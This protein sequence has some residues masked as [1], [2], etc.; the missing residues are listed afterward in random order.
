MFVS[1]EEAEIPDSSIAYRHQIKHI[2]QTKQT[3]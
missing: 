3:Q 2:T 1:V